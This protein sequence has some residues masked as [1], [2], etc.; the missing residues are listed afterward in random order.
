MGEGGCAGRGDMQ[1]TREGSGDSAGASVATLSAV[2][3]VVDLV[4]V[5]L[6]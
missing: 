2:G 4:V 3:V 5:M 1:D 6:L